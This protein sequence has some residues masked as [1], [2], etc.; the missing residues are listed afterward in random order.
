MTPEDLVRQLAEH[1]GQHIRW[2]RRRLGS[3]VA[4]EDVEDVLQGA[5]GRALTALRGAEGAPS[6][7]DPRRADAWLRTIAFNLA[8]D[9]T[10]HRRGRL[11]EDSE[12]RL[13]PASIDADD[14]LS[15]ADARVHLEDDVLES[16][17]RDAR[18]QLIADAIGALDVKHRQIL[19]LRYGRDLDPAAIMVLEGLSRRQWEGRH[20]RAVKAFGRALGRLQVS[21]EC[22][23]TRRMLRRNPRDLLGHGRAP[24]TDHLAT[25]VACGAFARSAQFAM[26]T[27]PL[28][29]AIA[30]WRYEAADR[31]VRPRPTN[32]CSSGGGDPGSQWAELARAAGVKLAAAATASAVG[33]FAVVAGVGTDAGAANADAEPRASLRPALDSKMALAAHETPAQALERSARDMA[34]HRARARRAG[35]SS[36]TP[37][38]ARPA[39]GRRRAAEPSADDR[40]ATREEP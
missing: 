14:G 4:I 25:C 12:Q 2:L 13:T 32:S 9:L 21:S 37:P 22:G 29:L 39:L 31:L 40:E 27:L 26:A 8:L 20:T 1:H 28:P 7:D 3:A 24:R 30:A 18:R 15:L 10:R 36:G 38:G 19:Q 35:T 33:M 11:C 16:L 5:Y 6:F 23:R 34:R 17:E